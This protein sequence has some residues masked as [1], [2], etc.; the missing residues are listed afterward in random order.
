MRT[1][2]SECVVCKKPLYRRPNELAKTRYAACFAHRDEAKRKFGLSDK[3]RAGLEKGRVKGTNHRNGYKHKAETREKIRAASR[4]FWAAHPEA[5]KARGAKVRGQLHPGWKGGVSKLNLSIRRMTEYR[6]WAG[7]VAQRDGK[8][9]D[10]GSTHNLEADHVEGL[11]ELMERHGVKSREDARAC[12]ALW[13][14]ANGRLLCEPC[15]Y[16]R[17]GR[18]LPTPTERTR[19]ATRACEMCGTGFK[20]KPSQ[21]RQGHGRFCGK[22]CSSAARSKQAVG[23]GN[24][25]WKGGMVQATCH[26]CGK[27]VFVKPAVFARGGGKFCSR[28]CVN[29]NR[30]SDV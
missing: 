21:L 4:E 24:P 27:E 11:A 22:A 1:P 6:R 8:C 29:A 2:N 10:C 16:K 5:A 12:A 19:A 15:H 26:E 13:D 7:A 18:A 9:V 14:V 17:H 30:R 20:V 28:E 3:E 23:V 25:N